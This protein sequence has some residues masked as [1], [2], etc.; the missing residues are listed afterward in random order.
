MGFGGLGFGGAPDP[1]S[2]ILTLESVVF[3][4]R[5]LIT[6]LDGRIIALENELNELRQPARKKTK[7]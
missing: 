5:G 3:G 1:M 7:K 2:R 4:L 6:Q